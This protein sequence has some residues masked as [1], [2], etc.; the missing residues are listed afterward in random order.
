MPGTLANRRVLDISSEAF[1]AE[2]SIPAKYTCDGEDINPPLTIKSTPAEAKSLALIVDD[3]DAPA[4]TWVHWLAWNI[5]VTDR[6]A[7]S[8]VP[9]ELGTNDFGMI[10]YGGPC[11][12]AGTHRY[13]FK[14]YALDDELDLPEGSRKGEVEEAMQDHILAYG[15]LVGVYKRS[16]SKT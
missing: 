1:V 13:F 7:E 5:P 9:G 4:G 15:E 11:P 12:P 8:E 2:G 16:L 14:V 10:G 3:P 6:I